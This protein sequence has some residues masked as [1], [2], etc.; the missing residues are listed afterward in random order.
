MS[1]ATILG[2]L[3]AVGAIVKDAIED[4]NDCDCQ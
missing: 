2:V 3:I 1:P 4:E